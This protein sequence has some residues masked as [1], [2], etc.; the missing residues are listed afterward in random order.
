MV[1][2]Q[3]RR[4]GRHFLQDALHRIAL[5]LASGI[6][7]EASAGKMV[8]AVLGEISFHG[9]EGRLFV[10]HFTDTHFA[11]REQ[12]V[13]DEAPDKHGNSTKNAGEKNTHIHKDQG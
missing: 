2:Q 13:P 12:V 4:A 3:S 1:D 7:S 5:L 8:K 10:W 11:H 9:V 6:W